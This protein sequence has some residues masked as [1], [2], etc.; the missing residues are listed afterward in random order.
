MKIYLSNPEGA[1]RAHVYQAKSINA[2][3]IPYT[4]F[5]SYIFKDINV[6]TSEGFR[7]MLIGSALK[8]F[9]KV[10]MH[11]N[12]LFGDFIVGIG[13]YYLFKNLLKESLD[14]VDIFVANS[15]FT[16]E[17]FLS[18]FG[19]KYKQKVDVCWPLPNIN[20]FSKVHS[21]LLKHENYNECKHGVRICY[22]GHLSYYDGA[23]LL[24]KIFINLRRDFRNILMYVIGT[25]PLQAELL[26][27]AKSLSEFKVL[28]YQ[29]INVIL[30]IFSKCQFFIYPARF[31]PFGLPVVEAMATGLIPLVTVKTGARDFVEKVN[32][33]LVT[34]LDLK[35]FIGKISELIT[36]NCASLKEISIKAR[37]IALSWNKNTAE[38][39]FLR[40]IK[41][42]LSR[43]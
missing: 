38:Q 25:G 32:P 36:M 39:H 28:G 5:Y 4:K 3:I 43:D 20:L 24:P 11:I 19:E 41:K 17:I 42:R 35:V 8:K 26:S 29:P 13:K 40:I 37:E 10:N 27:V 30:N 16:S 18:N 33:N 21:S 23:D 12:I 22:L 2:T 9:G 34:P 7:P 15:T 31:K 14:Y 1:H 6:L